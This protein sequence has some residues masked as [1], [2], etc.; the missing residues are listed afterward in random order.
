MMMVMMVTAALITTIISGTCFPC[1][2][3]SFLAGR[4]TVVGTGGM[5]SCKA[6]K[7]LT[8][9]PKARIQCMLN[10]SHVESG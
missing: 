3:I 9:L 10:V 6:R 7:T 2:C 4:C 5:E 8:G 1:G